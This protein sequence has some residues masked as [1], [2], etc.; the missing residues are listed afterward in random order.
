[1]LG[2]A[3]SGDHVPL[4]DEGRFEGLT[5]LSASPY[6]SADAGAPSDADRGAFRTK[7]LRNVAKTGP[8]MHAGQFDRLEDVVRYYH[9]GG[10]RSGPYEVSRRLHPLELTDAEQLQLVAFL[11][12]LTGVPVPEALGCGD[13]FP[14]GGSRYPVCP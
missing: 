2:I 13:A 1:V 10:D 8:W 3:Q 6:R 4:V 7:S 11:N 14:D 12:A 5:R 9:G